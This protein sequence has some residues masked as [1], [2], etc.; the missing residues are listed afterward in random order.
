MAVIRIRVV[1]DSVTQV[2]QGNA[3]LTDAGVVEFC[4]NV[5]SAQ[6]SQIAIRIL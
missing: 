1:I 4:R 2:M 6:N 5:G 3:P